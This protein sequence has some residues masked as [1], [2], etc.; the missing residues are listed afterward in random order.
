MYELRD[1]ACKK[2]IENTDIFTD[3]YDEVEM[4]TKAFNAGWAARKAADYNLLVQR[5]N[6]EIAMDFC[7][8]EAQN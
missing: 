4:V 3:S 7:D 1:E 6:S 5:N 2:L 8:P